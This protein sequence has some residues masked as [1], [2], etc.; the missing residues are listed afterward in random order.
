MTSQQEL[1]QEK[2]ILMS[3]VLNQ[4]MNWDQ[5]LDEALRILTEN[6]E[7]I[8]HMRTLDMQLTEIERLSYNETHQEIWK[9]I[10][11][12]QK[13]LNKFIQKQKD[14][15]KEQLVQMGKKEKIVSN[16][17]D[18]QKETGFIKRNY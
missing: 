16:Y 8:E 6:N 11:K 17:I 9:E 2:E 10:I 4:L 3:Q 7:S 1:I 12:I 18:I 15:T 14:K 5:S 13:I